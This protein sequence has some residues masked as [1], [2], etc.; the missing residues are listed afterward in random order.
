MAERIS[1]A[2]GP[3]QCPG[4]YRLAALRHRICTGSSPIAKIQPFRRRVDAC[5]GFLPIR[6]K[7][8]SIKPGELM[9]KNNPRWKTIP[10]GAVHERRG[11]TSPRVHGRKRLTGTPCFYPAE[12][13]DQ[14]NETV[15][16]FRFSLKVVPL[17][18]VTV[19]VSSPLNVSVKLISKS[20]SSCLRTP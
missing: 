20:P 5:T 19:T 13:N 10:A 16:F 6:F 18:R 3:G 7:W 11:R 2:M 12:N 1:W 8:F 15:P 17:P 14:I 9:A 4:L